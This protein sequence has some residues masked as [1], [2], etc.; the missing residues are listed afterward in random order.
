MNNLHKTLLV[1]FIILTG[2]VADEKPAIDD[3]KTKLKAKEALQFCMSNS[4]N[5]DFC[6]LIDM[7]LHSGLKRFFVYDFKEKKSRTVF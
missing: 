3:E 6:I 7:S 1:V 5:R 2:C 4:Y